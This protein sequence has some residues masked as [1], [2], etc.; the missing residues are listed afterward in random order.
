MFIN[1]CQIVL[2]VFK[3]LSVYLFIYIFFILSYPIKCI[4]FAL[5]FETHCSSVNFNVLWQDST[6]LSHRSDHLSSLVE[7]IS[8]LT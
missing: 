4:L 7:W 5:A 2:H 6:I 3:N 1:F 8:C